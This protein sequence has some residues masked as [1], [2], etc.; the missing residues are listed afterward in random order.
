[1]LFYAKNVHKVSDFHPNAPVLHLQNLIITNKL[2]FKYIQHLR[3]L[4]G[5]TL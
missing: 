2:I 4:K 1:M 5:G 3:K